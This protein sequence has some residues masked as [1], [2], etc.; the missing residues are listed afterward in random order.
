[1]EL[2][3]EKLPHE[4]IIVITIAGNLDSLPAPAMIE[5]VRL[6][7]AESPELDYLIVDIRG[8]PESFENLMQM[9]R[10]IPHQERFSADM[11][12]LA[13]PPVFVGS[14][15][16]VDTYIRQALPKYFGAA[17]T[18]VF[19][20]LDDALHYIRRQPKTPTDGASDA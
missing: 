15:S 7:L 9:L 19:R 6:A 18:P 17:H 1:M 16:L 14:S 11:N 10:L 5:Q 4:P 2:R 20:T 13:A 3:I 8:V 12:E